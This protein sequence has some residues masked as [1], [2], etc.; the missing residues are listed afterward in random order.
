MISVQ[1][2]TKL[3]RHWQLHIRVVESSLVPDDQVPIGNASTYD[4]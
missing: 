4:G 3:F 1:T 2:K